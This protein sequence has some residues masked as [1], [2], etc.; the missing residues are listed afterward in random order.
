MMIFSFIDGWLRRPWRVPTFD[1]CYMA[2][3][4]FDG[5]R[6]M[7]LYP[8]IAAGSL[9]ATEAGGRVTDLRGRPYVLSNPQIV[10]SNSLLH[11]EI[12]SVLALER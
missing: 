8:H 10:A 1:L 12:L 4:R 7:K 6:E 2:A 11:N 9:M 5:F 3:E